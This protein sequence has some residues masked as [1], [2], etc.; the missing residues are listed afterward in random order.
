LSHCSIGR[1]KVALVYQRFPGFFL[2][3]LVL[4]HGEFAHEESLASGFRFHAKVVVLM[5][6][7]KYSVD[8]DCVVIVELEHFSSLEL[9]VCWLSKLDVLFER[10]GFDDFRGFR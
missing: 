3:A 6:P 8:K 4:V 1:V 9:H 7:R 2:E 5:H 10:L